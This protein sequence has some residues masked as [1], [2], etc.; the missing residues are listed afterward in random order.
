[1]S[2]ETADDL[3][4]DAARQPAG[5]EIQISIRDFIGYWDARRRGSWV[6]ERILKSLDQHGVVTIPSFEHGWIDNTILLVPMRRLQQEPEPVSVTVIEPP[7]PTSADS[8]GAWRFRDLRAATAGL[9]AIPKEATVQRAQSLMIQ[10]DFSQLAVMSGARELMGAVSWESIT[11]A[12]MHDAKAGLRQA[13]V[14]AVVVELDEEVLPRVRD[15]IQRGFVFVRQRDRTFC[16]IATTTDLSSAFEDLAG[17]FLLIGDVE[18]RLRRLIGGVFDLAD[19]QAA[20]HPGDA[21]RVVRDVSDLA[22][23]EYIRL[24]D[25]DEAWQR[26]GWDAD[27]GIFIQSLH[28]FRELR[29]EVMHF[30]PDPLDPGKVA[31]VR[32]LLAW[33]RAAHPDVHE[34]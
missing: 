7:T 20:R 29:N 2:Y 14:P 32:H 31:V 30:S 4:E 12:K 15:I 3:L 25:R 10:N 8:P 17:P 33:L 22:V 26:L 9:T 6:V 5:Q 19:L 24:L 1:M 16:G 18:R 23:G 13:T 21:E 28:S 11:R 34:R 27:R